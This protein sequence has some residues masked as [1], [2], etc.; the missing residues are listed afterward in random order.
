MAVALKEFVI[1]TANPQTG[2][3]WG[4][5]FGFSLTLV[6]PFSK[7]DGGVVYITLMLNRERYHDKGHYF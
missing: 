7:A 2:T 6:L 1:F 3:L 4:I 5:F